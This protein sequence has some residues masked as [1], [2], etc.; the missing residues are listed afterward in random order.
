MQLMC[1]TP[2]LSVFRQYLPLVQVSARPLR[3]SPP[4]FLQSSSLNGAWLV[5]CSL[6]GP[7]TPI[8]LLAWTSVARIS[9]AI[10]EIGLS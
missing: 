1:V 7:V 4:T 9:K 5:G 3:T 6:L 8:G 10:K 2:L